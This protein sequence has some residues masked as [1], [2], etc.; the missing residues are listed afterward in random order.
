[1]EHHYPK[2]FSSV[3]GNLKNLTLPSVQSVQNVLQTIAQELFR[4]DITWA[5]I[6]AFY[7][8][9]GALAVDCV[10]IGHAEYITSLIETFATFVDRD[11]AS[12]IAQ[13]GGW[14]SVF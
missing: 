11:L 14:V 3:L 9:V 4:H 7:A 12:W 8:A 6:A 5:R 2:I 10:R 1:L 13:Q